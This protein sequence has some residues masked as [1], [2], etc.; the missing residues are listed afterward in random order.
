[1][2]SALIS[3]ADLSA[4]LARL[5]EAR[6]T[7]FPSHECNRLLQWDDDFDIVIPGPGWYWIAAPELSGPHLCPVSAK[8]ALSAE[9][10]ETQA[11]LELMPQYRV[12]VEM[13]R[14]QATRRGLKAQLAASVA[15]L[16]EVE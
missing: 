1:M 13:T 2:P 14:L 4:R 11:Q 15:E 7:S 10:E 9:I 5:N 12:P 8:G 6:V 3:D 16:A